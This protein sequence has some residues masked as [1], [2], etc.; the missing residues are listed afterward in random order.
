MWHDDV[1][2]VE[3]PEAIVTEVTTTNV[4]TTCTTSCTTTM[5]TTEATTDV[6]TEITSESATEP[7]TEVTE[8]V[9][10]EVHYEEPTTEAIAES[11]VEKEIQPEPEP[12]EEHLV[13]KPSTHYI[14]KNTCRWNSG[15]AY[16]VDDVTGLEA[17][18]CNECNPV[19]EGYTEYIQPEADKP[20]KESMTYVKHFTRGTYYCYGYECY[21]GSG[22]YLYDCSYGDGDNIKGSIA[23]SYLYSNYGYNYN[24]QR[25]TVYLEVEG[26]PSMSGYYYVDDSD[27]GNWNVI[28]FFYIYGSN[29]QFQNQGV[30]EVDCWI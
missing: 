3:A 7:V 6:T 1:N 11:P 16:R 2:K 20:D 4:T 24:G 23:S 30:V 15:D 28:D 18:L 17:R 12:I 29:C 26:Y 14:H 25:T 10:E 19:C 9:I 22:R 21:G 8:V 5:N 27:A 13:Y